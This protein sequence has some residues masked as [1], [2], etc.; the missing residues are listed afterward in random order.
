MNINPDVL[1]AFLSFAFVA[2]I[3][4]GPNNAMLM[5][6]GSLFGVKRSLPHAIGVIFGFNILLLASVFGL[7]AL[8]RQVPLIIWIIRGFGTLW[9]IW[10]GASF[11]RSAMDER[12][13]SEA[14]PT[15]TSRPIR[16]LEAALFQ[17]A[18]PKA[19][20][21]ATSSAGL[22]VTLSE[23]VTVRALF[24]SIGFMLAGIVSTLTWAAMGGVLS[25]MLRSGRTAFLLNSIMGVLLILTAIA[26]LFV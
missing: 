25:S 12:R 26:L 6:S 21:M 24:I 20:V 10:L 14:E 5:A 4:P 3:T 22:F 18:N 19:L 17:W 23:S 9:L 15:R 13:G 1:I 7:D 8:I 2:S 16:F 11:I